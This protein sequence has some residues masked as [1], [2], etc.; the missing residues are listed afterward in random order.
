[1]AFMV[2][3]ITAI[4]PAAFGGQSSVLG[5]ET[6]AEAARLAEGVLET[7]QAMARTEYS[8]V[9]TYTPSAVGSY[10]R[11]LTT[12]MASFTECQKQITSTVS[13]AG[14]YGQSLKV[15]LSS[16]VTDV[17]QTLALLGDCDNTPAGDWDNPHTAVSAGIG[18]VGATDIDVDKDFVYL[19]SD[20]SAVAKSDFYIY[21]FDPSALSLTAR[22]NLNIGDGL[23]ALDVAG[24]YAYVASVQD[25]NQLK[26]INISNPTT[27]TLTTQLSLPNISNGNGWSIA[28]Y[29]D[30]VYIG[31]D[32]VACPPSCPA[33]Q[34]NEL[35]MYDVSTPSA[36]TWLGSVD[37]NHNVNAIVV[38][39]DYAYLATS[40]N[41][42]EVMIYNVSNPAAITLVG[43]FNPSGNEDGTALALLGNRLYL[44][45]DRTPAGRYDFYI[46]NVANPAAPTALGQRNL[47]LN[48]GAKVK[49]IAVRGRL[50]FLG[51]DNP[52]TGLAI[53]NITN[54]ALITSQVVCTTL[55]FAE[56]TM[57][58]DMN[59]DYVFTANASNNEIRV[60]RDQ[61][62]S[63]P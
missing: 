20:P 53:L 57:A 24:S 30:R 43:T 12:P 29:D 15:E 54:P 3:V 33:S 49:G 60:L 16:L 11:T 36:P 6:N 9:D 23:A 31:T 25:V 13:W 39:G 35:H 59:G 32:Y 44:G 46:I 63:C 2:L 40:S 45:R 34:N 56:N 1:M 58:I 62:T 8:S 38:R 22:G 28:Y 10:T 50:A 47:G 51:L 61:P 37:V 41:D 4:A 52:T 19:T 42:S 17:E 27:P 14:E 21:E 26:V 48:P 7:A 5:G 55:N 18:G